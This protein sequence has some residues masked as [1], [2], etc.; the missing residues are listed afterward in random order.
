MEI[1]NQIL[2]WINWVITTLCSLAFGI[3]LLYVLLFWL[4][5]KKYKP[6]KVKHRVGIIIPARNE[7]SVIGDTVKCLL[8][9]DYPREL[10]D[11][12]VV[13]DNCTD[14]TAE[15]AR[16][17]GAIVFE[18]F[19][20]NPK[21][22]RA[23]Y[24]LQYGFEQ[25]LADYDNYEFFIKFDADNLMEPNYISKMNDAF[26]AGVQCARGYSNSKNISENVV[27]GISGLWYIRDCR[28]ACQVRSFLNT[29]QMLGGAG[30][31]F[32]A[33]I[34]HK[35][36]GWDCLSTSDD[37]EF[38]M[39]RLLEGIKTK[40]VS[41]A[42]VY[43]DQPTT[44]KD[45]FKRNKRMGRG[46]FGLFF[47][48]GIPSLGKFF[49]KFGWSYLD[50]FL[51]LL[52]VPI[53]LLCGVWMPLYYGYD[54]IYHFIIGDA[55]YAWN[56]IQNLCWVLAF[57]FVL[58]FILQ[59]LLAVILERKRIRAS[60]KQMIPTVLMFPAFMIIYAIAIIFGVFSKPKWSAVSRSTKV[61]SAALFGATAA[62]TAAAADAVE[63]TAEAVPDAAVEPAPETN[64]DEATETPPADESN[65]TEV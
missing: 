42:V 23:G 4:P 47:T 22:K 33:E 11:I 21:H 13:A 37:A 18:H 60:F 41:E 12:F 45:T 62:E 35:H 36:G 26:D 63:V 9:S 3:Q 59:A 15:I 48:K 51:N 46:L 10:Y 34:I 28:Y 29:S 32:S 19:D 54:I 39:N 44:V 38:A 8:N 65:V 40:Y 30:M 64:A 2:F 27:S 6:A 61:S 20:D 52:F 16:N 49:Y 53:A 58:A 43:E 7:A 17:A 1:F 57:A 56:V 55:P 24:A 5:S 14:N 31:M 25:I 50:M